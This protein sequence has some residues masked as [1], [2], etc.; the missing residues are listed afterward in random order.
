MSSLLEMNPFLTLVQ[1]YSLSGRNFEIQ[2]RTLWYSNETED[3]A[4]PETIKWSGHLTVRRFDR[5][6]ILQ[7]TLMRFCNV[8]SP[9]FIVRN[10]T[11]ECCV[12]QALRVVCFGDRDRNSTSVSQWWWSESQ[13]APIGASGLSQQK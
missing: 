11:H 9:P 7:L 8:A 2:K 10:Y 4:S 3:L 12:K 1:P 5:V 13:Q 6:A